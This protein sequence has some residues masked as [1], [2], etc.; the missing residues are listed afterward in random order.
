[1]SDQSQPLS[2]RLWQFVRRHWAWALVLAAG[3]YLYQSIS[4]SVDL[5]ETG[6]PAPDFELT[7]LEGEPFRLSEQRGKIVVLNVWATWCPPCRMEVPGFVELQDEYRDQGVL[8]VGLSVDEEGFEAVQPFAEEYEMNYPQVVG[9]GVA[10]Q[11]YGQT[12]T[13]PR[14][15]LIDREGRIRYQHTGLWMKGSLAA[16]LDK[17]IAASPQQ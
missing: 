7:T 14:T 16:A 13:V 5:P 8:F 15:Y 3:F 11:K 10:F 2:A 12:T 4:P 17:L 1:M 6:P 9:R